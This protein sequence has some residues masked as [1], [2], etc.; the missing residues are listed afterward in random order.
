[1]IGDAV[2]IGPSSAVSWLSE[3]GAAYGPCQIYDDE[4]WHYEQ[5]PDAIARGCPAAY[6]SPTQD[7][8]MQR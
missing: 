6:F 7:P 8:R 3:R 4:P 5:R 2:D 1:V